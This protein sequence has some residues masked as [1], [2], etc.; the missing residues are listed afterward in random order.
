MEI[1]EK[2][3]KRLSKS[4][5]NMFKQCPKKYYLGITCPQE[6]V[7]SPALVRGNELHKLLENVE[8]LRKREPVNLQALKEQLQVNPDYWKQLDLFVTKFLPKWS[9]VLPENCEEKIYDEEEDFVIMYDRIDYDGNFR[10]LWDYKSGKIHPMEYYLPEL[11]WYAYFF[12]KKYPDKKVDAVGIYYIDHGQCM[13]ELITQE[14]IM[15][16]LADLH[17]II[18]DI[19]ECYKTKNWPI[20]TNFYC[21]NCNWY[22]KCQ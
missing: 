7:S 2:L 20:K 13:T 17:Q 16:H 18:S 5:I 15:E 6:V 10:I 4:K 21:R 9:F 14:L 11:V 8:E 1:E 19:K 12:M 3:I 22:G